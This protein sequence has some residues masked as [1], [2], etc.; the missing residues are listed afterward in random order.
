MLFSNK[1]IKYIISIGV[2]LLVFLL[3][4]SLNIRHFLIKS[5][6]GYTHQ[7]TEVRIDTL[8][9]EVDTTLIINE[10]K[11][12]HLKSP[13]CIS[14]NKCYEA[15]VKGEPLHCVVKKNEET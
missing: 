4:S 1:M 7:E 5:L 10:W 12:G 13:E 6:G 15:L 14:C 8:E 3:L 2:I 11:R 9:I